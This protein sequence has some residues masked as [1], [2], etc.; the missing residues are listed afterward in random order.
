MKRF[1]F[2][3]L[4]ALLQASATAAD[5]RQAHGRGKQVSM[6]TTAGKVITIREK[7][8]VR[9]V[10]MAPNG[11]AVAWLLVDI[12]LEEPAGE[13]G[14]ATLV[15][16]RKGKRHA[17]EC[18]G[19]IRDYWFWQRGKKIAYDCGGRHFAGDEVLF[20][21]RTLKEIDHFSQAEVAPDKRPPWSSSSDAFTEK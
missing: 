8:P 13:V 14:A 5:F 21:T 6:I 1:A 18:R 2:V 9:E 19:L 4:A 7:Y 20:D 16:Y 12:T 15:V 10:R 3:I 17:V 11:M